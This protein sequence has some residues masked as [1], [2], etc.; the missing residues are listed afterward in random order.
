MQPASW[1]RPL[2]RRALLLL[3]STSALAWEPTT[4]ASIQERT[5]EL[6]AAWDGK[7]PAQI[8]QDKIARA[9]QK[10]PAWVD[11]GAWKLEVP[12]LTYYFAVGRA[13]GA[14]AAAPEASSPVP[15]GRAKA[16]R[17]VDWWFDE[18]EGA[19]YTLAVEAR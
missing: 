2:V 17:A 3:V 7:T 19:F 14:N 13:P 11:R 16:G 18:N 4:P 6:R 8:A 9:K 5:E 1:Y 10:R 12:P 15:G